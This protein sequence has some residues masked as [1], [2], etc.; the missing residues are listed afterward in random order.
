MIDDREL[1]SKILLLEHTVPQEDDYTTVAH[2]LRG[3]LKLSQRLY[4]RLKREQGILVNGHPVYVRTLVHVGDV[5]RLETEPEVQ[6]DNVP[7]E[8][9]LNITYEDGDVVVINKPPGICVHPTHGHWTGTLANGLAFYF[10]KIGLM[11]KVRPVHRLDMD[12]SGLVVFAKTQLA[13]QRLA[14]QLDDRTMSRVYHA[15]VVGEMSD[16]EG[17]MEGSIARSPENFKERVVSVDG[18][19]AETHYRV[20]RRFPWASHVEL[21]LGTG[22]THQIRVHMAHAGHPLIGDLM[23]LGGS[24]DVGGL[25]GLPQWAREFPRQAL[26]AGELSFRHPTGGQTV[27]FLAPLPPDMQELLD[28][29]EKEPCA[30]PQDER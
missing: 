3:R 20:L 10:E 13:H 24:D 29:L 25:R 5:I 21:R 9:P 28:H 27:R 7:E 17:T 18:R 19:E 15:F 2:I 14:E 23:Y 30:L 22:R 26:H 16:M 11:T 1:P 12:T 8:I 4:R 6:T